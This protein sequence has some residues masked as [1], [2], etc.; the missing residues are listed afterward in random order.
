[1]NYL[2]SNHLPVIEECFRNWGEISGHPS[3]AQWEL[4]SH[5]EP[6]LSVQASLDDD[7]LQLRADTGIAAGNGRTSR[8]L[9]WNGRLEGAAK[10][11]L[12][13][14]S[15]SIGICGEIPLHTESDIV[16]SLAA[17]LAG[18]GQAA[19]LIHDSSVRDADAKP[20]ETCEKP[21]QE[22][23][24]ALHQLLADTA[25]PFTERSNGSCMV[26]LDSKD[27]F[28][29]A[30]IKIGPDGCRRASV[31]LA[32]WE[33]PAPASKDALAVLLLTAAGV[34]RM[35]R[36]FIVENPGGRMTAGFEISFLPDI[37]PSLLGKGFSS[38]SIACRFCGR[39]AVALNNSRIAEEYL[40]IR[41]F[42]NE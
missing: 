7:W 9:Q 36:P 31:E 38:L 33:T 13:R 19:L 5:N 11:S 12:R 28:H 15:R 29:Q 14:E 6:C 10:F 18:F 1:M 37:Y 24:P 4:V 25:W 34:I 16:P 30:P 20:K 8:V 41:H 32:V 17:T 23:T 40:A 21:A 27:D 26:E 3:E 39:E 22:S 42:K 2:A 35:V